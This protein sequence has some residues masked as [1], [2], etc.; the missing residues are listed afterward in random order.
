MVVG[1]QTGYFQQPG[2]STLQSA[3]LQQHQAGYGLQ[4]NVFGTHNQSHTNASLQGF[5]SHF[6][7]TPIQIAAALNAQ[8]YR[9]RICLPLISKELAVK[10]LV[11]KGEDHSSWRVLVVNKKYCLLSS[12][13]VGRFSLQLVNFV[14]LEFCLAPQIPSPKSRQNCKQPPPQPSPTSQ[15][16]YNLYQ[17]VSNQQ[18]GQVSNTNQGCY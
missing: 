6:L 16:K 9:F 14:K 17:G 5:N 13:L 1:G 15:H 12:I 18:G 2:N 10:V 3:Q 8:Q 7:S 11:I 4:G